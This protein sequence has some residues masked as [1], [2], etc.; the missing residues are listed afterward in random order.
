MNKKTQLKKKFEQTSFSYNEYAIAQ[1]KIAEHLH[2]LMSL[3]IQDKAWNKILEIG[4]GTG[5]LS[6]YIAQLNPSTYYLNDLN[7]YVEDL[8]RPI[9]K[10]INYQVLVG[11]AEELQFPYHL[12]LVA[13]SS[14]FQWFNDLLDFLN[15]IA[16][17]IKEKGFLFFSSFGPDNLKEIRAITNRGLTYHSCSEI[18][19]LLPDCY[20]LLF[21]KEE[22]L[23]LRFNCPYD[24]LKHLKY[25]GVNA[26]FNTVWTK[27]DFK[28]FC[29]QYSKYFT[30]SA[31]VTLTYHPL[32]IGL[33][34]R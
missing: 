31:Q 1:K 15:Q 26:S 5:F 9:L 10:E 12:D 24:V 17:H 27:A 30:E 28:N 18:V 23:K 22:H 13:S 19:E 6:Q 8:L 4:C 11:D 21:A 3:Y 34:K 14:C 16:Q 33:K 25:T 7:E 20:E 2:H 32:Y 29:T